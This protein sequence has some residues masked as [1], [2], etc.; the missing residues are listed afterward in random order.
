VTSPRP[1]LLSATLC[2]GLAVTAC[3]ARQHVAPPN[4]AVA[5][6]VR[7]ASTGAGV[8]G[9]RI[10]LRRPG[11]LEPVHSDTNGDGAYMIVDLPAGHYQVTAYLREAAIGAREVDVNPGHLTGVDFAVGALS[12]R[13]ARALD[14]LSDVPLW[15]Y[16]PADAD[17]TRG[18][19]EGTVGDVQ[20]RDRV[21]GAV[22]T[23]VRDGDPT[24][25]Q[26]ITDDTG[27]YRLDGLAPGIYVV[28]AYYAVLRRGQIEV[29]RNRVE[30]QGGDVVVVPLWLDTEGL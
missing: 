13:A 2:A 25:V 22:V 5:G 16:R 28:S 23:A 8:P 27:R 24:A 18:A 17:P 12:E 20:R 29:R 26:A 1:L 30:V 14:G 15:R 10:V 4:G 19:I 7:D 3:A 21:D 6:L 11:S 9:T